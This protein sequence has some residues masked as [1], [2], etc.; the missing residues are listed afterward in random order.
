MPCLIH[1]ELHIIPICVA[2]FSQF[3]I[4]FNFLQSIIHYFLKKIFL[5]N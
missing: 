1:E 4:F 5:Y 2:F 3:Q